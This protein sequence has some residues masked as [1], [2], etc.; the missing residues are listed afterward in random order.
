[1]GDD[2]FFRFFLK[3]LDQISN[4]RIG[5]SIND[6]NNQRIMVIDTDMVRN[7][8]N[9]S[10]SNKDIACLHLYNLKLVPGDYEI[11]F[12][13]AQHIGGRIEFVQNALAF[14]ILAKD[15]FRTGYL[16]SKGYGHV[17]TDKIIW[18]VKNTWNHSNK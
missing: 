1:M 2:L 16:I 6:N 18:E 7:N 3:D 4:F 12:I 11:D 10:Y 14:N 15:V 13:I 9:L 8:S 5:I 17:Y